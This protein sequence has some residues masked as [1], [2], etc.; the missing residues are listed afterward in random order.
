MV[1]PDSPPLLASASSD[2]EV[3]SKQLSHWLIVFI[4]HL[5]SVFRL[6]DMITN[7]ILKVLA[8]FLIVLSRFAP[9]CSTLADN[10]F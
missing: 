7:C 6:S 5:R 10:F 9:A 2:K 1:R 4:I 3:T 8:A